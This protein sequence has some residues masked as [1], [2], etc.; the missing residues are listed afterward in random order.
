MT[1]MVIHYIKLIVLSDMKRKIVL[2]ILFAFLGSHSYSQFSQMGTLYTYYFNLFVML[3]Y[4][5]SFMTCYLRVYIAFGSTRRNT[6][7]VWGN[8]TSSDCHSE[9]KTRNREV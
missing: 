8:R 4:A 2:M 9:R 7:I 1:S 6:R 3:T 5:I